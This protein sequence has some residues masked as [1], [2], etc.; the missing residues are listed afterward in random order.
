M[1]INSNYDGADLFLHLT[2]LFA[3]DFIKKSLKMKYLII[4]LWNRI[5]NFFQSDNL[6][7][8]GTKEAHALQDEII[9]FLLA[10]KIHKFSLV[11]MFANTFQLFLLQ[12]Q[13]KFFVC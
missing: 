1:R 10:I 13:I 5:K 4:N 11:K 12:I 6:A 3:S 8:K 7:R 9:L 2:V